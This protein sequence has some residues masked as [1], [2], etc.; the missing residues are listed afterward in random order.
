M[1][2]MA[3]QPHPRSLS[4]NLHGIR[5]SQWYLCTFEYVHLSMRRNGQDPGI[6]PM[7]MTDIFLFPLWISL[8]SPKDKYMSQAL[9]Q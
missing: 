6:L 1:R 5:I 8:S 2:A 4:Q 9:A 3:A 7:L